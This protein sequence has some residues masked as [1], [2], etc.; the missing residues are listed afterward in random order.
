ML[1][2]EFEIAQTPTGT[3][4]EAWFVAAHLAVE[5]T[6][7]QVVEAIEKIETAL[8]N[9]DNDAI[10]EALNVIESS[11]K[12]SAEIMPDVIRGMDPDIF[13]NKIRPLLHGHGEIIFRGVNGNPAVTYIGETGAQSGVI[14]AVDTILNIQHKKETRDPMEKFLKCAPSPHQEYFGRTKVV[15]ENLSS[16]E[17]PKVITARNAAAEALHKFRTSHM[18]AVAQYLPPGVLKGTGSTN[19]KQFLGGLIKETKD[20]ATPAPASHNGM[21]ADL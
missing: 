18:A 17:N 15:G 13:L 1:P 2:D 20:T 11:M 9:G 6:G 7:G 21:S 3:K 10:V 19:I 5:S 14:R 12:F 4:D 8:E 16:V